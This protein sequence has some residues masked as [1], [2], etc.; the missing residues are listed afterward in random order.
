VIRALCLPDREHGQ[1]RF[2]M[3]SGFSQENA[4]RRASG[5][6]RDGSREH[7]AA[8]TQHTTPSA[9]GERTCVPVIHLHRTP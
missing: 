8:D 3:R 6:M 9:L 7:H 2:T 1:E 5:E 4:R